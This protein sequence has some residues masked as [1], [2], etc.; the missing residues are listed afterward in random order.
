[1]IGLQPSNTNT[2]SKKGNRNVYLKSQQFAIPFTTCVADYFD[3]L[4]K[5]TP[6][7]KI[8]QRKVTHVEM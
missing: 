3:S 5:I 1:M 4:E 2:T 6:P 8:N 7:V